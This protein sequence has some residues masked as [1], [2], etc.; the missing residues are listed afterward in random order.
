M[1]ADAELSSILNRRQQ[2]NDALENGE[3]VENTFR[4][5]KRNVYQEF[6]EFSRKQIKE[7]Q[8]T[9]NRYDVGQDGYLDLAELKIMMEKLGAPQTHL[10]LKKMISEVDEDK[11]GK[12]SFREFLLIYRKAKAGEL[13]S[14][15]GLE[16]LARLTEINVDEVGVNGAKNFFEA[17]IEE[18]LRTNKF[19]DEIRQEQEEKK[20]A[21]Q[22]KVLRRAQFQQKA[23][24]FNN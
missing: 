23:A 11:D 2:I 15:S 4:N 21:E 20:R 16:Q 1:S 13:T 5:V 14:E 22:E 24:I 9:F 10:S 19:H 7:Y 12:I 8:A 6:H 18:Q 17:K 3:N